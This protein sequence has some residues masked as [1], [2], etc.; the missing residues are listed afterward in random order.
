MFVCFKKFEE[1]LCNFFFQSLI[2]FM[3][4]AIRSRAFEGIFLYYS[5]NPLPSKKICSILDFVLDTSSW[6]GRFYISKNFSIWCGLSGLLVAL[7]FPCGITS[8]VL[9]FFLTSV[10][11]VFSRS[12]ELNACRLVG[13][14][15]W[16][17]LVSVIFFGGVFCVFLFSPY[18]CSNLY[19][20]LPSDSFAFVLFLVS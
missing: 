19:Y 17:P 2:S 10:I 15:K 1:D 5:F 12:V 7:C 11:W 13:L 20:F 18:L 9:C 8:N 4:I 3:N 14:C 16:S 6:L